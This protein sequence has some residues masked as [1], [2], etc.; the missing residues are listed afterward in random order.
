MTH[1]IYNTKLIE[2][3][4][5]NTLSNEIKKELTKSISDVIDEHILLTMRLEGDER[6]AVTLV[7]MSDEDII[8]R[9]AELE[10]VFSGKYAWFKNLKTLVLYGHQTI[11]WY[12]V[13]YG[14]TDV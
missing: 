13:T 11:T 8:E 10:S 12:M 2:L 14:D 1:C 5:V 3:D 9:L 6:R 4:L 7:K